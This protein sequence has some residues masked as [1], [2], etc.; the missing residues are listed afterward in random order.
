[1]I[2]HHAGKTAEAYAELPAPAAKSEAKNVPS[3]MWLTVGLLATDGFTI[4][5]KLKRIEERATR[6]KLDGVW[7][8]Y[9]P[10][11]GAITVRVGS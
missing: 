5:L 10:V 9:H 1:M 6:S 4:Q 8:V 7:H 11:G 2:V 3:S